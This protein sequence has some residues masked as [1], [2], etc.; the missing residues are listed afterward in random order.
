MTAVKQISLIILLVTLI[1]GP[2]AASDPLHYNLVNLQAE[3]FDLVDNDLLI[4]TLAAVTEANTARDAARSV[5][6]KMAWAAKLIGT[7]SAIKQQT[8]NYQTNPIYK[9]RTIAGWSVSQQLRLE[10]ADIEALTA[11][12]GALQEQLNVITLQ[13]SVSPERQKA[14]DDRLTTAAL[15][16][17]TEKA[18]LVA[19]ALGAQ[20]FRYVNLSVD[21]GGTIT[22]RQTYAMDMAMLQAVPPAPEV[23]AGE[24]HITIRVSGTIQLN[25]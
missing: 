6:E 7:H 21:R 25:F 4:V 3:A 20:D 2:A 24:S 10:S 15:A 9:N 14:A 11:L 12:T 8:L 17:F 5:N 16:A 1:A 18:R 19:T 22:D 13:F 23:A